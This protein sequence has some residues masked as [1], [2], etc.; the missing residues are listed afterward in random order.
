[1]PDPEIKGW[2]DLLQGGGN[3]ATIAAVYLAWRV[4]QRFEAIMDKVVSRL[5]RIER[6]LIARDPATLKILNEP[7]PPPESPT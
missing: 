5:G 3:V 7:D 1:M 4:F 2:L 6:A